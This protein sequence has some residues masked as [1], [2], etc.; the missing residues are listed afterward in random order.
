MFMKTLLLRVSALALAVSS[1]VWC[2]G[3]EEERAQAEVP[4]FT[5]APT[6]NAVAAS[7]ASNRIAVEST[8]AVPEQIP[9]AKVVQPPVPPEETKASPAMAEVIKLVQAGVSEEVT[10]TYVTNSTLPFNV[11]S[12]QIV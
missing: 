4:L 10:L 5:P 9:A 6:V 1:L 2:V 7:E 12:D 3:C 11:T 8:N